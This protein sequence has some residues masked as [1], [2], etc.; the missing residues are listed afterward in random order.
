MAHT[1]ATVE[2]L[3]SHGRMPEMIVVGITHAD[4]TR[5]LTPT[6][7]KDRP[8]SGGADKL[9]EFIDKELVPHV[10]KAY[11][12]QPYRVFAGH[13]L[14]GLFAVH[15]LVRKPDLFHAVIAVAPALGW[16]NRWMAKPFED[17]LASR[18]ELERTLFVTLGDEPGEPQASFEQLQ[19]I[20]ARKPPKGFRFQA[21]RLPGE[22]HGSV[23]MPSHYAGLRKIFDGWVMPDAAAG[24]PLTK[25]LEAVDAHYA[26]L[27]RRFGFEI[28]APEQLLNQLGYQ[29]LQANEIDGAIAVFQRNVER[30]PGSANVYDSLAEAYENKGELAP[31]VTN[32]AK[33]AKV[34][35]ETGQANLDIFRQNLE[36]VTAKQKQGAVAPK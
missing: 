18:P 9:L 11:R 22:D 2:Y 6:N 20:A 21:L 32:Y 3:A 4:R 15:A 31:A 36:R 7:A 24:Q 13:S 26:T 27:S 14:G 30:H 23:V 17:F 34:A 28:A 35:E 33:A 5:D 16:D 29:L 10:D 25:A 8:T 1:A 19:A 12:T